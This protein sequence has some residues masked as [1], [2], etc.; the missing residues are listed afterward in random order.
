MLRTKTPHHAPTRQKHRKVITKTAGKTIA[1]RKH[2]TTST[3]TT[4]CSH[5]IINK[6]F[7]TRNLHPRHEYGFSEMQRPDYTPSPLPATPL[8]LTPDQYKPT[9][10]QYISGYQFVDIPNLQQTKT[11]LLKSLKANGAL[12]RIYMYHDGINLQMCVH[13]SKTRDAVNAIRTVSN[14]IFANTRI[15]ENDI[16]DGANVDPLFTKMN[17]IERPILNDGL[18]T[19]FSSNLI[20]HIEKF[21]HLT[22]QQWHNEIK[23]ADAITD[24][25][26]KPI[27]LDIRNL[28]EYELG[29]FKNSIAV[30]VDAY[31][32]TFQI[33]DTLLGITHEDDDF[34]TD[35]GGA[36]VDVVGKSGK[37]QKEL[38]LEQDDLTALHNMV[39]TA[40]QH[41]PAGDI[42]FDDMEAISEK[43]AAARKTFKH[44]SN[45]KNNNNDDN[46]NNTLH[47]TPQKQDPQDKIHNVTKA[48]GD[49]IQRSKLTRQY[50]LTVTDKTLPNE[51]EMEMELQKQTLVVGKLLQHLYAK[52]QIQTKLNQ[53]DTTAADGGSV[54]NNINPTTD[55]N[56]LMN[57]DGL[58]LVTHG[59]DKNHKLLLYCTGGIR[60][61]KVGAYLHAKGFT[62]INVLNGGINQYAVY[63]Q[64]HLAAQDEESMFQGSNV[65][66]DNRRA[67]S[68]GKQVLAHCHQCSTPTDL[69]RNCENTL[70]DIL[71]IQCKSCEEDYF[72][73]CSVACSE[74]RFGLGDVTENKIKAHGDLKK[75]ILYPPAKSTRIRAR[76]NGYSITSHAQYLDEM[77]TTFAGKANAIELEH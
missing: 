25:H 4:T 54:E 18:N 30:D 21:N 73:T 64:Q 37:K 51:K 52:Q 39:T 28:Y 41:N 58:K 56:D 36:V 66:F 13:P 68:I 69:Q 53:L 62:N 10:I 55:N 49:L 34:N 50:A 20:P 65:V 1:H 59:V 9:H 75:P 32:D 45:N 43:F 15:F 8:A 60:C 71:F 12:G 5:N 2:S 76:L 17:I 47:N 35:Q 57:T 6:L 74:E 3:N 42:S 22:P 24:V 61:L 29:S 19:E 14:G 40:Q 11:D 67:V 27:I 70:C 72:G 63:H 77:Q 44:N 38:L 26:Q 48:E 7:N 23:A 33:L 16:V 46:N 31:R